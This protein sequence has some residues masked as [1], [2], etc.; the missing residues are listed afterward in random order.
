ML[1]LVRDF[2]RLILK[3]TL[4]THLSSEILRDMTSHDEE[5]YVELGKHKRL[6]PQ[7]ALTRCEGTP[8]CLLL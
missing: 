4:P 6:L 8:I 5:A 2:T 7:V 3:Y 1:L